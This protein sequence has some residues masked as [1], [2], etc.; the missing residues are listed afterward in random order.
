MSKEYYKLASA[1]KLSPSTKAVLRELAWFADPEG[2][3]AYPSVK[4]IAAHTGYTPRC[5]QI[6]LRKLETLRLIR[7]TARTG[8]TTTYCLIE[9]SM[10]LFEKVNAAIEV[11]EQGSSLG[12]NGRTETGERRSPKQYEQNYGTEKSTTTMQ[13]VE[14][15]KN[16]HDL[17]ETVDR[18]ALRMRI[19]EWLGIDNGRHN[20]V[21]VDD[22]VIDRLIQRCFDNDPRATTDEIL[23]FIDE[24][25]PTLLAQ[26][27]TGSGWIAERK[28]GINHPAMFLV[29]AV[30]N[31][32]QGRNSGARRRRQRQVE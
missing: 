17:A 8:T 10:R 13:P 2:K 27:P 21:W 11:G 22:L 25:G 19:S 9:E 15:R 23:H 16:G 20:P 14:M 4:K 7:G 5:V 1:L 3:Q 32:F 28:P 6:Q 29:A 26:R 18:E 12:A 24:K 31:C 30:A